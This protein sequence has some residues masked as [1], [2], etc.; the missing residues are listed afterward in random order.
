M[1]VSGKAIFRILPPFPDVLEPVVAPFRAMRHEWKSSVEFW[2]VF[3]SCK[4]AQKRSMPC[5]SL[6]VNRNLDLEFLQ[7]ASKHKGKNQH[8][9]DAGTK[10]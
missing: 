2:Q 3:L 9:K 1:I 6:A 4:K 7:S 8:T 5:S 10:N